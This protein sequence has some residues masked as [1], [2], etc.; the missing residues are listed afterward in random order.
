MKKS[1]TVLLFCLI[2]IFA[3]QAFG[4]NGFV[5]EVENGQVYIDLSAPI[6]QVG[7]RLTVVKEGGFFIHPVSGEKIKK[8]DEKIAVL[9]IKETFD[10]YSVAVVSPPNA[11][12]GIRKGMKVIKL[13][14]SSDSVVDQKNNLRKAIAV[15]P[16]RI[17]NN[18]KNYMGFYA[19]DLLAM[20]FLNRGVL[21]VIDRESLG[22]QIEEKSLQQMFLDDA[23]I[24][25]SQAIGVDYLILGTVDPPD[26]VKTSTGV[27][28][29]GLVEIAEIA[30]GEDLGS[31]HVSDVKIDKL[32]AIVHISLRVVDVHTGEILFVCEETSEAT[33]KASVEFERGVLGGAKIRGG[34]TAFLNS[35]TGKATQNALQTLA[36]VISDW[37][38]G[39]IKKRTYS[40]QSV[41]RKK[42]KAE[43][44]RP[45]VSDIKI[46]NYSYKGDSLY[47]LLNKSI[48]VGKKLTVHV[49]VYSDIFNNWT[50]KYERIGTILITDKQAGRSTGKMYL[51][52]N[53]LNLDEI[54]KNAKIVG[55]K[56]LIDFGIGFS[57]SQYWEEDSGLPESFLNM[58]GSL[59]FYLF[60]GPIFINPRFGLFKW[61]DWLSEEYD[62]NSSYFK[63]GLGIMLNDKAYM[64]RNG[65]YILYNYEFNKRL[66]YDEYRT[67]WGR[68]SY[69]RTFKN[70][71][72]ILVGY[73]YTH[74]CIELEFNLYN[75]KG[76]E[77]SSD[78]GGWEDECT[79]KGV[80]LGIYYYF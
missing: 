63:L 53:S 77:Y 24:N 7:D 39:K 72:N 1:I 78:W 38:E 23:L 70:K 57:W 60:R 79:H 19:S 59:R 13:L 25:T 64:E 56:S 44:K 2:I 11:I 9:I 18:K 28:L 31:E 5:L 12:T 42:S 4:Q 14:E 66:D 35:I 62:V 22:L 74:L 36:N 46:E 10:G 68:Y 20:H 30:T 48:G 61:N 47:V 73:Q 65:F 16:L 50:G 34:A 41:A 76:G 15:S 80:G 17:G 67:D 33:G 6:V 54:L 32:K 52:D 45:P 58:E 29:K 3:F 8:Q 40:G 21:R 43:I 55:L 51:E 27:P 26:V 75:E 49:P 69:Y 37:S 71:F